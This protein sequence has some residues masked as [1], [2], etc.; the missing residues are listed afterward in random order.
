MG[1]ILSDV[2]KK[3][4]DT[5]QHLISGR[6]KMFLS[7]AQYFCNEFVSSLPVTPAKRMQDMN[8][9]SL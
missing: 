9:L 2:K 7:K 8:V 4:F 6:L 1:R 5:I 3:T